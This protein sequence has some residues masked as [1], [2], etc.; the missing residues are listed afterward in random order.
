MYYQ[1]FLLFL[2]PCILLL[3]KLI[4]PEAFA[5][6]LCD[7]LDLPTLTFVPGIVQAMQTQVKQH[8]F[9]SDASSNETGDQR[10]LIKVWV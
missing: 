3:E 8:S 4:T 1:F 10:V 7:D 2:K 9:D 6:V 5:E